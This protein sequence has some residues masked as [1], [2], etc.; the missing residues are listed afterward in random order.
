MGEIT[1]PLAYLLLT[2]GG[3]TVLLVIMVI[4]RATL[5]SREDDQ[6][7]LNKA[8]DNM[9]ASEQREL[10]SKLDRLSRPIITLATLSGVLFI[11]SAGLWLWNG[12]K[13][14]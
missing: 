10:I 1:G 13:S 9:M 2:W 8:E 7:F 12:L 14:F 4:Y 3:V 6:I 5:S 11:A